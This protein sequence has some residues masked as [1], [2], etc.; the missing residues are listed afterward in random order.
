MISYILYQIFYLG[1]ISY[2]NLDIQY[3]ILDILYPI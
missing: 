3:S 1:Y 2:T